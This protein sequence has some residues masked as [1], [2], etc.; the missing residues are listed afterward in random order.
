[1]KRT[2]KRDIPKDYSFLD[3]VAPSYNR[4]RITPKFVT[5][6][7]I[8]DNYA[9]NLT[10]TNNNQSTGSDDDW[11][12]KLLEYEVTKGSASGGV[13]ENWG[14]NSRI[15]L[16][17]NGKF[18]NPINPATG[19]QWTIDDA[20]GFFKQ[21]YLPQ[22][23]QYPMG[24]RERIGDFTYNTGRDYRTY[25]LDQYLKSIGQPG[26]PNRSEYNVDTKKPEWTPALKKSLDDLWDTYKDKINALP[27]DQQ[28]SLLDK[29]R[30]TYYQSINQINGKPNPAYDA[31]WKGRLETYGPYVPQ[32]NQQQV[33]QNPPATN[34]QVVTSQVNNTQGVNNSQINTNQTPP[35]V[36]QY[37]PS[38]MLRASG[39]EDSE[40]LVS[41]FLNTNQNTQ[42]TQQAPL[43]SNTGVTT[44]Q[45]AGVTTNTS[46][47]PIVNTNGATT[48]ITT[49][50]INTG[51]PSNMMRVAGYDE[52]PL[53]SVDPVN[54][55]Q[56]VDPMTGVDPRK[57]EWLKDP[58]RNQMTE[59]KD[60]Q[61]TPEK[62]EPKPDHYKPYNFNPFTTGLN[63]L[64]AGL[65]T[66]G[67]MRNMGRMRNQENL[68]SF[69]TQQPEAIY[70]NKRML[71]GD[72][73]MFAEY[74][75]E[76]SHGGELPMYTK[77]GEVMPTI[78]GP[79]PKRAQ[80]YSDSMA[81]YNNYM[82]NLAT[83]RSAY[84]KSFEGKKTYTKEEKED[85]GLFIEKIVKPRAKTP[86]LQTRKKDATPYRRS[87]LGVD[88]VA[89]K[90]I[91]KEIK[92]GKLPAADILFH[93]DIVPI[94]EH[95]FNS[96]SFLSTYGSYSTPWGNTKNQPTKEDDE[97]YTSMDGKMYDYLYRRNPNN[98]FASIRKYKKP[99][100]PYIYEP[101]PKPDLDPIK[102]TPKEPE[103]IKK[104]TVNTPAFPLPG[105]THRYDGPDKLFVQGPNLPNGSK[106]MTFAEY[107]EYMKTNEGKYR[108]NATP[109]SVGYVYKPGA[110]IVKYA[111]G[112]EVEDA[113]HFVGT[114]VEYKKGGIYIKPE[115]K[116][117][118]TAWADAHGMSVQ[119]AASHVMANKEKYSSTTVKRAN[120]AKNASKFK[121]EKGGEI[122]NDKEMVDGVADILSRVNDVDNRKELARYMTNQFNDENVDYNYDQFLN[123][124]N[125]TEMAYGGMYPDGGEPM[126][127]REPRDRGA[128]NILDYTAGEDRSYWNPV[129]RY[130]SPLNRSFRQAGVS[131]D[132]KDSMLNTMFGSG[133]V[134]YNVRPRTYD[135]LLVK[136]DYG[137]D[138]SVYNPPTP[139]PAATNV[140][141][142]GDTPYNIFLGNSAYKT[143]SPSKAKAFA[144][145]LGAKWDNENNAYTYDK[146]S[147]KGTT[148]IMGYN[149]KLYPSQE[150][151]DSGN[152]KN[153]IDPALYGM[154]HF[155]RGGQYS[156][157]GHYI[158]QDVPYL[159]GKFVP[160][161][162]DL[163]ILENGGMIKR[164]DGT[165]SRRGLWDN[166]R[167]N[168]GSGKK[169]TKEMLKQ[170]RK[171][172]KGYK[173]GGEYMEGNEYEISGEELERLKSLGYEVEMI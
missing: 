166:I 31:T 49:P 117:K 89:K 4:L 131:G 56:G 9:D 87:R 116:G 167:D 108:F 107:D 94:G 45:N 34:N 86:G 136:E 15:P 100:Q 5:G 121:H 72:K 163:E 44:N 159:A 101:E 109:N 149:G 14:Y 139:A 69:I 75:G 133:P 18:I 93:T 115:N 54:P 35:P 36:K 11:I 81:L 70:P 88:E 125:L 74:G 19:K 80:S 91:E 7:G 142:S 152:Y 1:M 8:L 61:I 68:N 105:V 119:E 106:Y 51:T 55:P 52:A 132:Q 32:V 114:L 29:G 169:P 78:Y 22:L 141:D 118:F 58:V 120:F 145:L 92:E 168:K 77:A 172:K 25:M 110:G 143:Y 47:Q 28:V 96:P 57:M 122:D 66:V 63:I 84:G 148:W 112:G 97:Y 46:Q 41:T 146:V 23:S 156:Y 151:Y 138:N 102:D 154:G 16:D 43:G 42:T 17:R 62:V 37:T 50:N 59:L 130:F 53:V 95:W 161:P 124:T 27:L 123:A 2:L 3:L 99:V 150:A 137:M 104:T 71:Y 85:E 170:E 40:G 158:P 164:A 26:V 30:D 165:Y 157:G 73:S 134:N 155:E 129:S 39:D 65:N 24:L 128:S 135:P 10:A 79:D 82:S 76:F 83:L 33:N 21:D 6:G 140:D 38:N 171:I 111:E 67:G 147:G 98:T 64:N 160:N 20:I 173:K 153:P 144:E 13:L 113:D 60:I 127:P 126:V 48:Q 162:I 103:P 90:V 12:R